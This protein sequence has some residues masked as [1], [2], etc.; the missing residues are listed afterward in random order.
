[1][2]FSAQSSPRSRRAYTL[3]SLLLAG[4]A[5]A[6]NATGFVALGLHTSHMSG[7]MALLGESLAAGNWRMATLG[8]Q[9]LLSFLLGAVTAS[10][11]LEASRHRT[12]GRHASAL[13]LEA[14]ML[15]GIGAWLMSTPDTREPSLMWCLSFAMG[16]QNALVT[17]V[18]GAVVRTTHITGVITDIGIQLV[19]MFAWVRDGARGHGV[20]GVLR[21]VRALPS[22]IQFERTRLHLG[23]AAAFL[24]G[25]TVGPMLFLQ[26]GP[27]TLGLPCAV[28]VLLVAL[29]LS[30][31][32]RPEPRPNA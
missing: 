21:Q 31:V 5:G 11:L 20:G 1:M 10:A 6:V 19:Q 24:I 13:L 4:V 8:A 18:S 23:L 15:G 16:L 30:P 14:G 32:A 26:Y 29:D 9:V 7:N 17:R 27:A 3:L 28:L 22:A 12:R 25:C 2:P